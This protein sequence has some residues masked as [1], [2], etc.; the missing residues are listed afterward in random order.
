[1]VLL[2]LQEGLEEQGVGVEEVRQT[3]ETALPMVQVLVVRGQPRQ[4]ALLETEV[5]EITTKQEEVVVHRLVLEET[6]ILARLRSRQLELQVV[7][8]LEMPLVAQRTLRVQTVQ[9]QTLVE[10]AVEAHKV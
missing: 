5:A 6:G 1:M 7:Q 9:A 4:L 3:V 8:V 2:A 10:V